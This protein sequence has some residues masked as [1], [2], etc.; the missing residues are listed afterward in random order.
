[1]TQAFPS[2]TYRIPQ[3]L[4]WNAKSN[5]YWSCRNERNFGDWI[6]PLLFEALSG[7]EAIF[8]MPTQLIL[9][10]TTFTVGSILH[11]IRVPDRVNVWGSGIIKERV[12]FERPLNT[13]SVRGPRS[14]QRML[15][16]GYQ[17]PE[18]YG[19]PAL[20]MPLLFPMPKEKKY[21]LGII[22]HFVD[23]DAAKMKFSNVENC[24][25]IDVLEP[26]EKVAEK[27]SSCHRVISSSLHG[28]IVAHAY[29]V[30]AM[31]AIFSDDLAGDG[32][33]FSDYSESFGSDHFLSRIDLSNIEYNEN[34]RELIMDESVCP[35][36]RSLQKGILECCP[37]A[38]D[39]TIKS[40]LGKI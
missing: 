25:L 7:R 34:C 18:I 16:Q 32:V 6:G 20:L 23:S 21:E 10:T 5:I 27:I 31:R 12:K 14:R 29:G 35:D 2:V 30:P 1:M 39:F 37:F 28:I 15:E 4:G 36:V 26:P 17:C 33:K 38:R 8:C 24:L 3:K 22:P 9:G 11:W 13:Y 40:I 19:D